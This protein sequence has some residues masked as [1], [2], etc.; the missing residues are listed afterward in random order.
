VYGIQRD[1]LRVGR[2]VGRHVELIPT[3]FGAAPKVPMESSKGAGAE[4]GFVGGEV[5]R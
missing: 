5:G 2:C 1:P 3:G 4:K